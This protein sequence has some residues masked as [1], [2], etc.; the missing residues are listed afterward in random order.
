[1]LFALRLWA[2]VCLA[3]YV[4]FALQLS[5]PSWAGTTAALVCQPQLG[6]SMRKATF[7]LIGTA[8]G[9]VAIVVIAA[10]FPQDRV[11]FLTGLALWSAACGFIG[12]L[13]KNFAAYGAGLAGFTAAVIASDVFGPTGGANEQVF[14]LALIRVVEITVGIVSAGVVLA[15]TD[16]GGAR[17]RLGGEL[18]TVAADA[19]TGFAGAIS[20]AD[21]LEPASRAARREVMR[22][23]IALDPLI[24]TAIGEASDLRYRSRILQAA[25]NGLVAAI[26]AWRTMAL[27]LGRLSGPGQGRDVEPVARILQGLAA[28]PDEAQREPARLRDACD[29]AARAAARIAASSPSSQ[30]LADSAA[31]GL[32]GLSRALNGVTL[33]VDPAGARREDASALLHVPDW[34]PPAIVALRAFLTAALVSLFWIVTAWSSGPLALTFAIVIAVLIPLQG[35]RAYGVAMLFLLGSALSAVLSAVLT[36]GVLPSVV[37]FP[38]LC[39]TLGLALVPLGIGIASP[40][41]P[42]FFTAA[43]VHLIP[44]MSLK[45][46]AA[47]DAAQFYNTVLAILSGIAVATILIRI[48]PP[49]SPATRTRRLLRFALA[50]VRRLARG[51]GTRSIPTWSDRMFARIVAIPDSAEPVERAYMSAALATGRR[52]IRLREVAPRFVSRRVLDAALAPLAEGRVPD[53]L[54]GLE[55]LDLELTEAARDAR[56]VRRLRAVVLAMSEELAE[57][58]EFFGQ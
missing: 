34:A 5:D 53:A 27:H 35:D 23:A 51:R 39:L 21:P 54:H 33:V 16:L 40:W 4:A 7:R 29:R 37:T 56:I 1:M 48:L 42:A 10:L 25:V 50:D 6:A 46:V 30:L 55:A 28:T 24:D 36:F 22:R 9:G 44:L 20:A 13:L 58:P 18:A 47:Y 57:F 3:L 43:A 41:S 52:I 45:N 19:L 49:P 15:L 17:R 31:E 11:G 8:V 32:I 38:G 26:S 14:L 12:A 2:S